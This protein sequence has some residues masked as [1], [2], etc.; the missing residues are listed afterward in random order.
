MSKPTP[1][2]DQL[3]CSERTGN[4]LI[5]VKLTKISYIKT[6]FKV[7]F[8]QNFGLFRV[9][10]WQD[11]L[12]NSNFYQFKKSIT[13][14]VLTQHQSQIQK[15]TSNG[16]QHSKCLPLSELKHLVSQYSGKKNYILNYTI[17]NVYIHS[18]ILDI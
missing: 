3:L 13:L 1:P 18:Y 17:N 8:I 5:Q 14:V 9:R 6:L 12:Y 15:E 4:R 16:F 11:S 2:W 10:I 7:L